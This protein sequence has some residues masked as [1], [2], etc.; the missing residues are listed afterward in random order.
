VNTTNSMPTEAQLRAVLG[1]PLP[2]LDGVR[3]VAILSLLM[4]QL[5][6]DRGIEDRWLVRVVS[7]RLV[8]SPTLVVG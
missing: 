5:V 1:R 6:L 3:G 7:S 2:A 8:G 4:H